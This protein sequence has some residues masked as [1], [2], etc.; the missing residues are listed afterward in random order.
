MTTV[1]T[2]EIVRG[3]LS[4]VYDDGNEIS[5]K[6]DA[7][8]WEMSTMEFILGLPDILRNF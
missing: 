2:T 8:V 7:V 1:R 6:V 5:A 4:F 3:N